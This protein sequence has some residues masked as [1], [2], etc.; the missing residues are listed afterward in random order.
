MVDLSILTGDKLVLDNVDGKLVMSKD[1]NFLRLTNGK[2][3]SV[4]N[5]KTLA[6]SADP[7]SLEITMPAGVRSFN[8]E[9]KVFFTDKAETGNTVEY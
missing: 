1:T 7:T 5:M 8:S 9:D 6:V 2:S 4:K 3:V